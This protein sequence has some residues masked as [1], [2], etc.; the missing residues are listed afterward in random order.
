MKDLKC[1]ICQNNFSQ[2]SHLRRHELM[3]TGVKDLECITCQNTI[4]RAHDLKS[5][6]LTHNGP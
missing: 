1:I 2:S 4:S 6:E 3:H 5:H